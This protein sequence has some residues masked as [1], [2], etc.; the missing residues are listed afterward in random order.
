MEL[1]DNNP[2]IQV[3]DDDSDIGIPDVSGDTSF[4][5]LK[6]RSAQARGIDTSPLEEES[7]SEDP[8]VNDGQSDEDLGDIKNAAARA[9]I[10]ERDNRIL[11]SRFQQVMDAINQSNLSAYQQN[12][13]INEVQEVEDDQLPEDPIN[14]IIS[15]IERI[16]TKL[17][18]KENDEKTKDY[19]RSEQSI[20]AHANAQIQKEMEKSPEEF[21]Q[22]ITFLSKVAK[23]SVEEEYPHLTDDEQIGIA[24]QTINQKKMDWVRSGKNPA[25]EYKKLAKRYNFNPMKQENNSQEQK[26]KNDPKQEIRKGREKDSKLR[27]IGGSAQS[28]PAKG[29]NALSVSKMSEDEWNREL[30]R[31]ISDG[32]LKAPLGSR[33]PKFS[34]LLAG[35]G[36]RAR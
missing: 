2:I 10:L 31:M 28:S 26:Q 3:Q 12:Q 7:L 13:M 15:K 29:P 14:K 33:T 9:R 17:A 19:L 4:E 16:E 24:I 11:S 25:E 5:G 21:N 34:D 35:K 36:V 8:G 18:Q 22:I 27:S 6:E 32:T 23:E 20:L 1:N 30:D